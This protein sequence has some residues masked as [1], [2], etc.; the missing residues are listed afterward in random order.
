MK[1][2]CDLQIPI[3]I[4][5][6]IMAKILSVDFQWDLSNYHVWEMICQGITYEVVG[7][8]LPSYYN[9]LGNTRDLI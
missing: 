9:H 1:I 2:F 8:D 3:N 5:T 4:K 7:S 6:L